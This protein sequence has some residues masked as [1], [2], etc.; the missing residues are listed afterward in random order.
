VSEDARARLAEWLDAQLAQGALSPQGRAVIAEQARLVSW[1]P[2]APIPA[3]EEGDVLALLRGRIALGRA[4]QGASLAVL[5]A[6]ALCGAALLLAEEACAQEPCDLARLPA[7]GVEALLAADPEGVGAL[8]Q[9]VADTER[10]V[11]LAVH[12]ARLF[13]GLDQAALAALG[14]GVDWLA[15]RSGEW[16]FREGDP[17]DAAYLLL[18]GRLR[19]VQER[20]GTERLLN[21]IAAGETVGEMALL[22]DAVRSASVYAVRDSQLAKLGSKA[23]EELTDRHPAALRRIAGFVVDRLRRHG[24][25][26]RAPRAGVAIAVLA[27]RPGVALDRFTDALAAALAAQGSVQHLDRRRVESALGR[28]GS[29]DAADESPAGMRLVRWLNERDAAH[30]VVLYQGDAEW[31]P[32]TE[33]VARQADRVLVVARA[34]DGAALGPL[35]ERLEALW[36]A[37]RGADPALVLLHAPGAQPAGT[38]A[39]LALRSS[40][41]HFHVREDRPADVA[42][43]ARMLTGRGVGL[44]LGGGGARGFAHLGVLQA[45]EEAGVP[46]DLVGGT[47][48]GSIIAALPAQGLDAAAAREVCRRYISSLFDP[49]LPVVSLLAGRRIGRRVGEAMGPGDIEDLWLPYFCVATNLSRA[50]AVVAR[51]GPLFRAVRSS[52]SLPGILPPVTRDG[53]VFVDGGLLNNL[54][55]DVMQG[56]SDGGPVIAVD[57]SP[58]VDLRSA[59]ELESELSGWRALWQRLRPFGKRIDL[60]YI[61]SVLM[62]SALVGSIVGDRERRAAETASLYLKMPVSDWG[63][64]EFE[65]LD[66]IAERGYAASSGPVR[67]WWQRERPQAQPPRARAE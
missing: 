56:L 58:D 57:V 10:G 11:Q 19:A 41:H 63:L 65:K 37:A 34:A 66:A 29:A 62:R 49:T 18:S 36:R 22:T 64:L 50:E 1:R 52:I 21:E 30:D 14:A 16:L 59:L 13:P 33:R 31:S 23:F 2:G 43:V 3:L 28:R 26:R 48:I 15:L 40:R 24:A 55:I 35:E 27:A 47:S 17:G 51:R 42:R 61:S 32:W 9:R 53:E 7:A 67:E 6:G 8:V 44:V 4:E 5:E 12:L 20:D 54:P 45:L 60:P 39:W 25:V 38:G 46:I